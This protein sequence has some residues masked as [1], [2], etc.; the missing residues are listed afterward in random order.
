MKKLLVMLL[1]LLLLC[2]GCGNNITGK[3]EAE[4]YANPVEVSGKV[5]EV[6]VELGQK[7]SAGD[8][9]AVLDD[10]DGRFTC[11]QLAQTLA[12]AQAQLDSLSETAVSEKVRQGQNAVTIAEQEYNNALFI[13]QRAQE[14]LS[15]YQALAAEGAVSAQIV[16]SYEL[17]LKQAETTASVMAAQLD[18]AQQS[19]NALFGS[20]TDSQLRAA[21][22]QVEL[23]QSKLLQAEE[24]LSKYV[25]YAQKDG[26]IAGLF[27]HEG[28]LASAG[29]DVA[30]IAAADEMYAVVYWPIERLSEVEYDQQVTVSA[31]KVSEQGIIKYLDIRQEYTPK[32]EQNSINKNLR[33]VKMKVLLP[34]DTTFKQGQEVQIEL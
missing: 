12:Q 21:A 32:D 18:S 20:A 2:A 23:A 5:L 29:S 11:E 31:G 13:K 8:V 15:K 9:L 14:D 26:I 30:D 3:V 1:S 24:N 27:F 33:S 17:A 19:L 7:V 34:A 28:E 22:A 10:S 4:I 25:V 16:Q 6:P